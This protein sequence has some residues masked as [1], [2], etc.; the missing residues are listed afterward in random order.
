M[1]F[2]PKPVLHKRSWI[3]FVI[4]RHSLDERSETMKAEANAPAEVPETGVESVKKL[5]SFKH[6]ITPVIVVCQRNEVR[7][8]P[9]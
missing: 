7:E 5:R 9:K 8:G 3:S 6:S 4:S 2:Q 1:T